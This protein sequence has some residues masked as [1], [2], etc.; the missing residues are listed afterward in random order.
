MG[1]RDERAVDSLRPDFITRNEYFLSGARLV[2]AVL[3]EHRA[4]GG[5][6]MYGWL[7]DS[8]QNYGRGYLT[9][10]TGVNIGPDDYGATANGGPYVDFDGATEA[11]YILDAVWQEAGTEELFGFHWAMP[12]SPIASGTMTSKL[13]ANANNYSWQVALISGAPAVFRWLCN[14]TGVPAASVTLSSTLPI[15]AGT[16]Y[17]IAYYWQASTLM[18][19]FVGAAADD[20]LTVDSLTIGVPASLFNGTAPLAIGTAFNVA[21]TLWVPFKG[22]IGVGNARLNTPAANVDA[23]AAWLFA[24]TRLKYAA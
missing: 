19:L 12:A 6:L 11:W 18:R 22:R 15:I 8:P 4:G 3:A 9:A 24:E 17:F 20:A 21:P 13:D 5:N 16:W 1:K 14:A 7:A 2:E 23:Y 10:W